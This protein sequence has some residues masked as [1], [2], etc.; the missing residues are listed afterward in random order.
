MYTD[1]EPLKAIVLFQKALEIE[2][3]PQ[4]Y[5]H[6]ISAYLGLNEPGKAAE[7]FYL[8]KQEFSQNVQIKQKIAV[9]EQKLNSILK[10][11]SA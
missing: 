3:E 8:L 1:S 2:K 5:I 9:L 6:L 7:T 10:L 4:T 11:N